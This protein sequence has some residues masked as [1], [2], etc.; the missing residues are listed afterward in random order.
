MSPSNMSHPNWTQ[1][2]D[3]RKRL[4]KRWHNG[5]LLRACHQP[6]ALFPLRLPL[7]KPGPGQLVDQF[8]AARSWIKHWQT[9][10]TQDLELEWQTI[11][12]RQLGRN[13]LPVAVVLPNLDAAFRQIG[14]LNA[15]RQY[16]S[17]TG[18]I[19]HRFPQLAHWCHRKPLTVLAQQ[20]EWPTLLAI[21]EWMAE[22]PKPGIYIR[23]LEIPSVHT[24]FIERNRGLLSELLD[25]I[26]PEHAI[27]TSASGA[28][29][30]EQRY[31]FRRRPARL[32]LRFLDPSQDIAG[33]QDIEVPVDQFQTLGLPV[34]TVYI[35]EN[36]VTALAFPDTPSA[37][38]IFGQGYGIGRQ[39]ANAKWLQEK[40]VVYWGDIDSHGFRILNQL[41]AAVPHARSL[42]MDA[43]TLRAH[44]HLWGTEP[45]PYIGELPNLTE[46]EQAVY[47]MLSTLEPGKNLRLEQEQI[48]FA[49]LQ[50]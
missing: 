16:Q 19:S 1:L 15:A 28:R 3:I 50:G 45:S 46:H 7:K 11:N 22:N 12:N 36:D 26:L 40:S 17:L 25:Q 30:F 38:V 43:T 10:A 9:A 18:E 33:L 32:R 44:Q 6:N 5:E 42:L 13:S 37:I 39:L 4:E 20:Q 8:D 24:K 48:S 35:V 47:Q 31:G 21:L 41:R 23:Q 49:I 29:Q 27:D 14:Q 34:N 2:A